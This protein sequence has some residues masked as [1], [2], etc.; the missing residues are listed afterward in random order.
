MQVRRILIL[1]RGMLWGRRRRHRG[2][3]GGCHT[4]RGRRREDLPLLAIVGQPNVGKSLLFNR[5]TGAYTTVS[6]Y[7]GTTVEVARGRARL[8][9]PA[10][11]V[12]VVDTPGMY[13]LSPVGEEER[14]ARRILLDE[15]PRLVLHVVDAKNLPRMLPLTLQLIEAGLPVLLV[16]NLL[17]EAEQIGVELDL[18]RLEQMLGVPVMGTVCT[19]GRGIEALKLALA[20]RM[21]GRTA[22]RSHH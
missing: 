5:L 16:V 20:E 11:E 13:S 7:P 9:C 22:L 17:D 12:A 19:T 14:V 1:E 6:N 2:A 4:G 15:Q 10:G 21:D 18:G 8:D 3:E